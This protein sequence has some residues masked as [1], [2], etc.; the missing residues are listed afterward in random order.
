MVSGS[1]SGSVIGE[2][3]CEREEGGKTGLVITVEDV[4]HPEGQQRRVRRSRGEYDGEEEEED[5]LRLCVPRIVRSSSSPLL[6]TFTHTN[7]NVNDG[8]RSTK[9]MGRTTSIPNI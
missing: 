3:G 2:E 1:G 6:S 9:W 4:D 8:S 7:A 5:S